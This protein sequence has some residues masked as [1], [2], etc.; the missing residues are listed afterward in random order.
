MVSKRD[1][2]ALNDMLGEKE[3]RELPCQHT[4]EQGSTLASGVGGVRD[5]PGRSQ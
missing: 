4:Q 1:R 3:E 5:P 2:T